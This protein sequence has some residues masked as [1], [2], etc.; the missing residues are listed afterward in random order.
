MI[1]RASSRAPMALVALCALLGMTGVASAAAVPG[2]TYTGTASDGATVTVELSS[3]GRSV[4]AYSVVGIFGTDS[5]GQTCQDTTSVGPAGW[6]GAPITNDGFHDSVGTTFSING[7]F[8][9]SRTVSGTFALDQAAQGGS[10]GCAT[11]TVAWTATTSSTPPHTHNRK[12]IRVR[13][14]VR[15]LA[16]RKL[17]GSLKA[18]TRS[19]TARR[20]VYLWSGRRRLSVGHATAAGVFR[21][22]VRNDW[23]GRRVHATVKRLVTRTTVCAAAASSTVRS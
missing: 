10:A 5:H 11:G 7:T 21:F 4:A 3:N 12:K 2:A 18:S 17:V 23:D 19:C 8:G 15:R 22:T 20:T 6:S 16:L 9:S 13:V 14:S 1:E